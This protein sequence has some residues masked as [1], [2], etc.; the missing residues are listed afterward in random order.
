LDK[1][2][3]EVSMERI[4]EFNCE[5]KD[6]ISIDLS[7]LNS[8]EDFTNQLDLIK[9][10]ISKYPRLSLYTITNI[11]DTR[12]N[13]TTREVVLDYLIHNKPYIKCSVIIGVDGVKKMMI[14]TMAKLSGRNNV[15]CAF[16]KEKAIERA[17]H[18]G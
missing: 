8:P 5:G 14:D 3:G 9:P 12:F 13:S 6:F 18:Q 7:G 15:L 1:V 10:V 17:L 16:T 11:A 4:E 2:A